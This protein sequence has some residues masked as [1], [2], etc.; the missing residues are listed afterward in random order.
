M[1]RAVAVA[2]PVVLGLQAMVEAVEAAEPEAPRALLT[3]RGSVHLTV[4]PGVLAATAAGVRAAPEGPPV[5]VEP[6]GPL[7]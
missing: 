3:A 6:L 1:L 2:L 5:G 4:L 7:I